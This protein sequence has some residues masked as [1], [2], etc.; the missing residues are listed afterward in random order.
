MDVLSIIEKSKKDFT[1]DRKSYIRKML[2]K[3]PAT[4]V[5]SEMKKAR[6][7]STRFYYLKDGATVYND[8]CQKNAEIL[9]Q[10]FIKNGVVLINAKEIE[11]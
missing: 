8:Y 2:E 4:V 9:K 1:R 7:A 6:G 3:Y 10:A 11:K 5:Y